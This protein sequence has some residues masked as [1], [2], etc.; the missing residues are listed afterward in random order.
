MQSNLTRIVSRPG[1][2]L[3]EPQV[4]TSSFFEIQL[5][6]AVCWG[7]NDELNIHEWFA[8]QRDVQS[9]NSWKV[10]RTGMEKVSNITLNWE[11]WKFYKL[12]FRQYWSVV[13]ANM[14]MYI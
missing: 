2:R 7:H 3:T 8:A 6:V 14:C 1:E 13:Y 9:I 4:W 10:W 12:V 11:K 5:S